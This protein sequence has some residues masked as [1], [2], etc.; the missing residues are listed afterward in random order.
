MR[1]SIQKFL[2]YLYEMASHRKDVE[3]NITNWSKPVLLHLIK[4]LKWKDETDYNH[5]IKNINSWLSDIYELQIKDRIK[6]TSK[7]YY[8]WMYAEKVDSEKDINR[9]IKSKLSKYE[10]LPV[11]RS[12]EEI[13]HTLCNIYKNISIDFAKRNYKTIQEYL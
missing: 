12:N 8:D 1:K 5:H 4:I 10:N 3:E 9:L 13:Y 7:N 6:I 11:L 2:E